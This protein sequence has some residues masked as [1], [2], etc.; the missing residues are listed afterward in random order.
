MIASK[1]WIVAPGDLAVS[2]GIATRH[3][4]QPRGVADGHTV[5]MIKLHACA[6]QLVQMRSVIGLASITLKYLLTD[7]VGENEQQVRPTVLSLS[8]AAQAKQD[9]K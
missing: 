9:Q 3:Q 4:C 6:S 5:G 8:G 1:G 7:V 2:K